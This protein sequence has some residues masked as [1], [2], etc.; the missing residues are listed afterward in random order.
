MLLYVDYRKTCCQCPRGGH[1]LLSTRSVYAILTLLILPARPRL[2]ALASHTPSSR[3]TR[4]FLTL[5]GPLLTLKR[6]CFSLHFHC[7]CIAG[8]ALVQGLGVDALEN[9]IAL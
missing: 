8:T 3:S 9:Q 4:L 7:V 2:P 6:C 1:R 5:R